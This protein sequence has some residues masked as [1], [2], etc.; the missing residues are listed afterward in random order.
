MSEE[1]QYPLPGSGKQSS[2]WNSR[3]IKA[4]R[5]HLQLTQR[6]MADELQVRQQTISEWETGIHTPHRS[7]QKI[8]SMVAERAGFDY[9][10]TPQPEAEGKTEEQ[11]QGLEQ[12]QNHT[13]A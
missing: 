9:T 6:Q 5:E 3:R 12:N 7:T 4:L 2:S 1:F 10:V 13:G 11:V 8:L